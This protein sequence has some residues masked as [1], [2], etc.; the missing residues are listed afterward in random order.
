MGPPI[1]NST[2]NTIGHPMSDT[3]ENSLEDLVEG[4]RDRKRA[5]YL[6]PALRFPKLPTSA[7]SV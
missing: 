4:L 7:S 5:D 2:G 1:E 3:G 6:L